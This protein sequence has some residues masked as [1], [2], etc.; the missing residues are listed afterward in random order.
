MR[1]AACS[2]QEAEQTEL[3]PVIA[4]PVIAEAGVLRVGVDLDY[5]PLLALTM[6]LQLELM[7]ILPRAS[8]ASW[9]SS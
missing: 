4:P 5:P 2:R 3:T 7:S 6:V 9:P 8:R 1:A